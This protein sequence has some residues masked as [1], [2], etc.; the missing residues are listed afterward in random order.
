MIISRI[1]NHPVMYEINTRVKIKDFTKNGTPPTLRL[2][3]DSY[4]Q[5]LGELGIDLIWLMGIWQTSPLACEKYCFT[6]GLIHDYS[7]SLPDWNYEDVIGSPYAIDTYDVHKNLGTNEDLINLKKKLNAMGMKLILDFVPNHMSACSGL[8]YQIP[9]IFMIGDE[10]DRIQRP[11]SFFARDDNEYIFAH[12]RD[13]YFDPWE[14]TV[15]INCFHDKACSFLT[16]SLLKIASLCDGV[17]CDMAMLLLKDIFYKT[18]K[19]QLDKRGFIKP[20][21]EFWAIAIKKVRN[22]YKDF[23]F[24]AETYWDTGW[25]LQQLG[26]NFTYDK[27]LYDRL[28][29][30]SANHIQSHFL[31]DSTY[32]KKSARFIENHDEGRAV[33]IFGTKKSKAAAIVITTIQGLTFFQDGQY[34]GKKKKLPVQLGR[35]WKEPVQKDLIQFY[36]SLLRIRQ[37]TIL[38]SGK[39]NLIQPGPA[40]SGNFTHYNFLIWMWVHN[41][42]YLL[43]TINYSG[44]KSQCR[45]SLNLPDTSP[46]IIFNDLLGNM[47]YRKETRDLLYNGLYIDRE[48]YESHIF[49]FKV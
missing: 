29:H 19:L 8:L 42:A 46:F 40:W 3:P 6:P 33:S 11:D 41:N 1:K 35:E 44:T 22:E 5:K 13:P 39:W 15:Q 36:H 4:W 32:Q 9:E 12:G 14:D 10:N 38:Q 27:E 48:G 47:S 18:W 7:E 30:G 26:F 43:I 49:Y 28:R 25:Q 34:E 24:I 16:D 31:A 23:L 45:I 21:E 17:R 2:I 37:S 20:H